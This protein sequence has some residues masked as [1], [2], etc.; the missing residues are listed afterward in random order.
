MTLDEKLN[1]FY[2]SAINDATEQSLKMI[3]NYEQSLEKITNEKKETLKE[4]AEAR[5]Q[6]ETDNLL[7]EKNK[8]LSSE[9]IR[10]KR[11]LSEKTS[12]KI[13][14]LFA[15]IE[16]KLQA[17][18]KTPAYTDFLIKKI[19]EAVLFAGNDD[20]TIYINPTDASLK[21]EIEA[22]VKKELTISTTD[23]MGGIRC[24]IP[25]RHILIDHS[26]LS[27]LKEEKANFK[28]A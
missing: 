26:F 10:L 28:L 16:K 1:N 8:N 25:N 11:E 14:L 15:D 22:K 2:Q 24:V 6:A 12:E 27:K 20:L 7:R 17:Y 5:L 3:E 9:S 4:E 13:D 18:M 23:F 21:D 19:E